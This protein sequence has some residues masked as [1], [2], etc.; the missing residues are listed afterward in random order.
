[1]KQR[2]PLRIYLRTLLANFN[3]AYRE[4]LAHDFRRPRHPSED[5]LRHERFNQAS[6]LLRLGKA[7]LADLNHAYAIQLSEYK[8]GDHVIATLTVKGGPDVQRRFAIIDVEWR[9]GD[10]QAYVVRQV[11]KK[12]TIHERSSDGWIRAGGDYH[13]ELCQDE[14]SEEATDYLQSRRRWAEFSCRYDRS[15]RS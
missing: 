2:E 10:G 13:L 4:T 1:M 12:G 11:T 3:R 15:R 9:K 8:P 5:N 14:L 7:C 6:Q